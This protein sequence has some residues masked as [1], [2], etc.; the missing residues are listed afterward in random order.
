VKPITIFIPGV[1]A[2]GGSKSY[3]GQSKAGRAILRDSS[4]RAPAWKDSVATHAMQAMNGRP[5]IEKGTP[6]RCRFE[7]VMPRPQGHYRTGKH[8][9]ELK[10]W[11]ADK[12]HTT[13]PDT[14]KLQRP[15][16]DALTGIV[17]TDDAQVCDQAAR[18]RYANPGEMT[19]ARVTIEVFTAEAEEER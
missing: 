8:A 9:G 15:C 13:M 10:P 18:K 4:K 3:M 11:A 19:G 1:P 14:L 7:F 12:Q 2:P 16:E 6:L 17:W 5:V